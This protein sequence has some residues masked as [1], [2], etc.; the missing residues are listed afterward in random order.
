MQRLSEWSAV[1]EC[2]QGQLQLLLGH[3]TDLIRRSFKAR[4]IAV[5]AT[6]NARNVLHSSMTIQAA[7]AV[8]GEVS[9]TA[10]S[11]L[12]EKV[13]QVVADKDSFGELRNAVEALLDFMASQ[14]PDIIRMATGPASARTERARGAAEQLFAQVRANVE[15][16]LAIMAF[17]FEPS[18]SS[19][20]SPGESK[21]LA[22][23]GG[24]RRGEFWDD[25]WAAIAVQLYSGDLAPKSQADV[26]RAMADWI[27]A[28]GESA[29][30]S[31]IRARARRLWDRLTVSEA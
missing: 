13:R 22:M 21:A 1:N 20:A 8:M 17:D 3:E 25:M 24:R 6:H 9:G 29:A 23:K 14:L 26:E 2:E 12:S 30:T 18:A 10:V 31:T 7:V 19:Q 16:K 11:D 5:Y 4:L 27:E 15:A 28:N